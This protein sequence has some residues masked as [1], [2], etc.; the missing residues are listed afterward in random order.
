V[1]V[2]TDRPD[3]AQ[4]RAADRRREPG[5]GAAA[6]ELA[7]DPETGIG[8]SR[9]VGAEQLLGL[10]RGRDGRNSPLISSLAVVPATVA[11]VDDLLQGRQRRGALLRLT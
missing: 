10:G 5:I 8:G 1:R 6:R 9:L 3:P 2:G 11:R 7:G 4:R